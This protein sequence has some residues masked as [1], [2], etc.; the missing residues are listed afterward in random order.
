MLFKKGPRWDKEADVVVVGSGAAG[1]TAALRAHDSGAKVVILESTALIGGTSAVSGGGIWIPLNSRMKERGFSDTREDALQYCI[2]LTAG[3]ADEALV[4]KFVDTAAQMIDYVES[5]TPLR[6]KAMTA[7]DYHPEVAGGRKGGR[8]VEA[9]PFDMNMLGDWRKCVR[10]AAALSFPITLQEAFDDFQ[11]FYRPWSI[12]QD[13]V[14]ERMTKGL[15][16][17]GQ[18][19][20]GGLLKAVLDRAIPILLDHPAMSLT[21]DEGAVTGI[22]V[23]HGGRELAIRATRGVILASG[24]FEWNK[25]L[26]TQFLGGPELSP[27]S[28]PCA[29]GDG[30]VMAMEAGADL[31]NMNELWHYPS[32]MIPGENYDGQPMARGIKAER[33]GPHI[34]W[35]NAS[36]RRF[37][38]EAANYNSVGRSFFTLR[39]DGPETQNLPA[40]A[41]FDKQFRE[42]YVVGTTMPEDPDPGYLIKA[43]TLEELARVAGIEQAGLVE[44]VSRW[45]GFVA[46]GKDADFGKGES[47]FDA[48]QGDWDAPHP[49]LGTVQ[50]P[51]FYALRLRAGALGTKGGPRTDANARVLSVRGKPIAGLYAAGNVAASI[52]GPSYYGVGSTL[53]PAMTWGYVAGQHAATAGADR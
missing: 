20:V 6:F 13:I 7:R 10:P 16:T 40:W 12:P 1:M 49:N 39:T 18:A 43:D 30:L 51:P 9:Q 15:A 4:T 23:K 11:A 17:L 41:I 45:N 19:L 8:S 44:T 25:A 28:P 27:N 36:G 50:K 42:R 35:V 53:G 22:R 5:S 3:R 33:S 29:R 46:A 21:L 48:Y 26:R 52:C 2:A 47:A 24:G 14:A 38:N 31:A 37:V 32:L 34:I